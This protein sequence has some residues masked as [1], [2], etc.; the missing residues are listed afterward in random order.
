MSKNGPEQGIVQPVMTG[1]T[2]RTVALYAGALG[3]Y[4]IIPILIDSKYLTGL[5]DL[6]TN[7]H[8]ALATVL[9]W[10]LVFRTNAAYNRWWEAR[11]LWGQLV[12]CSRNLA[13]KVTTLSSASREELDRVRQ[14]IVGFA[15]ILRDNLR[16]EMHRSRNDGVLPECANQEHAPTDVVQKIYAVLASW[17]AAGKIDIWELRVIDA[18][19]QQL[20]QVC[21]GCERIRNTRVV[22]SY[23]LFTRQCVGLFLIS[24][25]WG[26]SH[27]FGWWTIPL[28][29]FTSYF[30]VGLEV[31]AEKVEEPFG[32]DEDDLDLD[33]LCQTIAH[34]VNQVF[35]DAAR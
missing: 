14:L 2:L 23:R 25:P 24:F 32:Y 28:T 12:N 30:M 31:V 8:A 9:G 6:P 4:S 19:A 18:D 21:G 17:K 13:I 7:I 10:L 20:L 16:R 26:V 34:S 33:G 11:T 15:L 1:H 5:A 3:I 27:S 22:G 35:I 29:I